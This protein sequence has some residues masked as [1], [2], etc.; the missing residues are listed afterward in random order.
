MLLHIGNR[1][2]NTDGMV[3]VDIDVLHITS[4]LHHVFQYIQACFPPG[5]IIV[6]A[7]E[8]DVFEDADQQSTLFI[9]P[10]AIIR[11]FS[12]MGRRSSR[13]IFI[14]SPFFLVDMLISIR[15][16]IPVGKYREYHN[17]RRWIVWPKRNVTRST[18]LPINW[19]SW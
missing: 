16:H 2:R 11:P 18:S 13:M 14:T 7:D 10:A 6:Q 3:R 9:C 19:F 12:G 5:K 15:Y 1:L 4:T 8:A 17:R